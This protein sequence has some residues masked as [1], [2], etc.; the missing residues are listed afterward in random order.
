MKMPTLTP[1]QKNAVHIGL[2]LLLTAVSLLASSSSKMLTAQARFLEELWTKKEG[3]EEIT[4]LFTG[5]I[6]LDRYIKTLRQQREEPFPFSHMPELITAV[7]SALEASELDL[8]IGNL[9]GPITDSAY[10]NNGTAMVFNFEPGVTTL[11]KNAGFTTFSMANNHTLDMGK[12]GIRQTH[13][14]LAAAGM[15]GFGHPDTPNGDYS[16]ITYDFAG[17]TVGFLGL[18]DAVIRLDTDAAVAKIKEV[19]PLVD[20]LIIG[21]HWGFEYEPTARESVVNKA[22]AFVDA[23]ADFIWGHHPHVVQNSEVYNGV[24]IYYSLGNFVFDQYW[25][26]ETQIG[27]VLGVKIKE[28]ILTVTEH[29]VDLVDGGEPKL[30]VEE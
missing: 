11:L 10:V 17:T 16:F 7:Q 25:S 20:H 15:Q 18:N 12:D 21:V 3:S 13:D 22:H 5:D 30:R 19:D 9:E 27:L 2:A 14:Y 23:G 26:P 29:T 4:M 6:M 28:G 1:L 24:P 8:I